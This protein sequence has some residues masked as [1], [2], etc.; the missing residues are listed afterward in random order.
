MENVGQVI[1]GNAFNYIVASKLLED[2]HLTIFW[3]P[4]IHTTYTHFLDPMHP[5]CLYL[6]LDDIG[7]LDWAKKVVD[8]AK[9]ITN[10]YNH[11]W[12]LNVRGKNTWGKELIKPTITRFAT[13]FLT[14][15]F[16]ISEKDN[17]RKMFSFDEWTRSQRC[18]WTG[19][20]WE[21]LHQILVYSNIDCHSW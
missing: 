18:R 2:K 12:L 5:H 21:S 15:H 17:L 7:K 11:T 3:T 14:L 9:C 10:I 19:P 13:K 20:L 16:L 8:H 1:T 6:M 4:C